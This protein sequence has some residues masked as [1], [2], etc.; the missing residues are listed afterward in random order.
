MC[1][2]TIWLDE[3]YYPK[4]KISNPI[5]D[6]FHNIRYKAPEHVSKYEVVSKKTDVFS[7]G[8]LLYYLIT[9]SEPYERI[10]S[11]KI[12]RMLLYYEHPLIPDNVSDP[13]RE[14]LH[15]CWKYDGDR[16][17]AKELYYRLI[18]EKQLQID[19]IDK[20]IKQVKTYIDKLKKFEN[21]L[22][23]P[24]VKLEIG[25]AEEPTVDIKEFDFELYN[26][27]DE[28][29][30]SKSALRYDINS[31]SLLI[32]M[33]KYG[34]IQDDAKFLQKVIG[35]IN[36]LSFEGNINAKEFLNIVFGEPIS[37]IFDSSRYNFFF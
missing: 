37:N 26:N 11:Y 18:Q 10:P 19:G 20:D 7:Y 35:D 30:Y 32:K 17:T 22:V 25:Y 36:K 21:N 33:A 23:L 4:I 2:E 15:D 3:N 12:E 5:L 9:G 1:P 24:K 27:L 14:L 29:I 28:M 31:L 8:S 13:F 6:D 16:P 34:Y